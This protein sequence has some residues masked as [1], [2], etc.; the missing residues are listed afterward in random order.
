MSIRLA[1]DL[2]S[3]LAEA[4]ELLGFSEH[5]TMRLAMQVGLKHFAAINHDL[6]AAVLTSSPIAP[7]KQQ[8]PTVKTGQT[9]P[10]AASKSNIMPLPLQ[11]IAAEDEESQEAGLPQ[12]KKVSY[13]SGKRHS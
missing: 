11:H 3:K 4:S 6:A 7:S 2:K 1:D 12:P 9:A 8:A 5:D 13:T 10:P